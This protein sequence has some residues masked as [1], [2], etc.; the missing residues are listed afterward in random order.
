MKLVTR[1]VHGSQ[2]I[3]AS[4]GYNLYDLQTCKAAQDV[5]RSLRSADLRSC[6]GGNEIVACLILAV[7][8]NIHILNLT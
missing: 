1:K 8:S 2:N 5:I 3:F 6:A 7:A 4:I